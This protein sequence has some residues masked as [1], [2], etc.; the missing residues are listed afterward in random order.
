MQDVTYNLTDR[1]H[2]EVLAAVASVLERG[3]E[4]RRADYISYMSAVE[5]GNSL[6][7]G[8]HVCVMSSWKV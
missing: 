2:E 7:M 3:L 6:E 4:V 8:N 5:D 1:E